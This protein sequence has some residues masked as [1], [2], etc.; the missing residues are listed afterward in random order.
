MDWICPKCGKQNRDESGICGSCFEMRPASVQQVESESDR[1]TAQYVDCPAPNILQRFSSLQHRFTR[2]DFAITISLLFTI[3]VL[4]ARAA[5]SISESVEGLLV[6][7]VLVV[8]LSAFLVA[9]AK[10]CRDMDFNPWWSLLLLAS[11]FGTFGLL[12][13]PGTRGANQ[14]GA[15]PRKRNIKP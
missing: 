15:D 9:S 2:R 7:T 4:V 12:F 10:R 13:F 1:R 11:A 5:D 8:S 6:L 3:Q 14:Y